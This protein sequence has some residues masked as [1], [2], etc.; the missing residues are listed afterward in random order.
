MSDALDDLREKLEAVAA[1]FGKH[2]CRC[3]WD[4]TKMHLTILDEDDE[5]IATLHIERPS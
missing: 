5:P 1:E 2:V 3:E 4:E